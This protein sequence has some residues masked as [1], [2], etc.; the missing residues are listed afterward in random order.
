MSNHGNFLDDHVQTTMLAQVKE[1]ECPSK[2]SHLSVTA[3]LENRPPST[4]L[5]PDSAEM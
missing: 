1:F 4:N 5:Q 2:I 3:W